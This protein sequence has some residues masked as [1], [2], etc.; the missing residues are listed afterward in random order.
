MAKYLMEASYT[1]EGAKG[2][3]QEGGTKRV[4]AIEKAFKGIGGK[5]KAATRKP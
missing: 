2:L 3:I 5:I 1:P 4:R